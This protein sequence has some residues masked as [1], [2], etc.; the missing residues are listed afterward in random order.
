MNNLKPTPIG[1]FPEFRDLLSWFKLSKDDVLD[2][3]AAAAVHSIDRGTGDQRFVYIPGFRSDRV[4]LVAH[5]DT[6]FDGQ[7]GYPADVFVQ[8]GIL[9]STHPDLACGADDRAGCAML[10]QMRDLGH[11]LLITSGE[12]K[13][14]RA[15]T[16]LMEKNPDLADEINR[17]HSFVVQLDRCNGT[18]FKCYDVGTP[19]F[20]RYVEDVTGYT[21]PDR[22]SY[23][24]I[25]TLCRDIPGVNLSIGYYHEHT[26]EEYLDLEQWRTSLLLI[27]S[28]L[29]EQRLPVF[30]LNGNQADRR[31]KE[32]GKHFPIVGRNISGTSR[33]LQDWPIIEQFRELFPNPTTPPGERT[34]LFYPS[35]GSDL[36]TPLLL[37]LPYC[38]H[39]LFY[40][41]W[42]HNIRPEK[43]KWL[44]QEPFQNF[45]WVGWKEDPEVPIL[46][47][48]RETGEPGGGPFGEYVVRFNY[49]D[50]PR[51]LHW[52]CRDNKDFLKQDVDLSFYFHR[53]DSYGEGGS[54]QYW[55]SDL[56]PEMVAKI[57]GGFAC[58]F[59]S[60]GE[61][62][63]EYPILP[64][65]LENPV[66]KTRV[67]RIAKSYIGCLTRD[68]LSER[69]PLRFMHE[70]SNCGMGR[71]G[72]KYAD[73]I[74]EVR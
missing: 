57:P 68:L 17:T 1:D 42:R 15:S 22:S 40:E 50:V 69:G 72:K 25:C 31:S 9:R 29:S 14:R 48:P 10:W 4:L 30:R 11:S 63:G 5:A 56:L 13:G 20:R 24:D 44:Q 33:I 59:L 61:P 51:E 27:R 36:Q 49:R 60:T 70:Q 46:S 7:S 21:E 62:A 16:W 23:T 35:A 28:W 18:D 64:A 37:G 3:F 8:G 2:C 47:H 19:H 52:V 26:K 71:L 55:D 39:F 53:G 73:L 6:Y 43:L 58:P 12:E 38:R 66:G 74:V 67:Y 65:L 34:V 54:G 45:E 32:P 41:H